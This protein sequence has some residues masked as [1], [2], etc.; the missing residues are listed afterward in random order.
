MPKAKQQKI[1]LKGLIVAGVDEA[2]RGP[3]AGPVIAAAVILNPGRRIN[4][5]ADSK[6]LNE[7]QREKL[8]DRI[9]EYSL[10]WAVGRGEVEEIDSINILRASLL[11]MRR[12]VLALKIEPQH[13]QVDGNICPD[14]PFPVT[15][16]VDGDKY[17]AAVS[18]ASIIAKVTRDREMVELDKEYPH[19][20]FA[21]HKGYS[22]KEHLSNLR[23]RGASPIH[24]QS[25]D[26][27]RQVI[28]QTELAFDDV[29]L[30]IDN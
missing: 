29:S 22:T 2:G 25:F 3:L 1:D 7:A 9:T 20:G 11:A 23:L 18:A 15:A 16:H 21:S 19:Y 13:V 30:E 4:G 27:V 12:A 5:L 14:V 26:P 24:R 6:I 28:F 17:I 8:Y 10:A